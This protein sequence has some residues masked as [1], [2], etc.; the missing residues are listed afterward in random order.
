MAFQSMPPRRISH[1]RAVPRPKDKRRRNRRRP[2]FERSDPSTS[3]RPNRKDSW[4]RFRQQAMQNPKSAFEDDLKVALVGVVI[5]F[6]GSLITAGGWYFSG[7]TRNVVIA[8]Q[9]PAAPEPL[10]GVIVFFVGFVFIGIGVVATML[11]VVLYL[12]GRFARRTKP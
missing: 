6:L 12:R 7:T 2:S 8:G 9:Q 3:P 1:Q 11:C 4:R 5:A 10:V